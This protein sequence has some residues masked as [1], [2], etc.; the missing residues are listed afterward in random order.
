AAEAAQ[1]KLR[2]ALDAGQVPAAADAQEADRTQA[3]V[4]ERLGRV[5]EAMGKIASVRELLAAITQIRDKAREAAQLLE[6][7]RDARGKE[8][9]D[10]VTAPPKLSA[11]PVTVARGQKVTVT[12]QFDKPATTSLKLS[13]TAPPDSSLKVP[14]QVS[15]PLRAKQ[16][17]FE[18]TAGDKTG[19]FTLQ[20]APNRGQPIEV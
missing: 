10:F 17:T 20:V 18:L 12:V 4:I 19:E 8:D 1:K 9:L 6:R 11:G 15:V 3:A 14:A 13:V 5:L 2:V 16:A 7:M